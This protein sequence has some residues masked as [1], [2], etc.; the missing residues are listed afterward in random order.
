MGCEVMYVDECVVCV[1]SV[2]GGLLYSNTLSA[3]VCP[4]P[5]PVKFVISPVL[6][7]AIAC[8]RQYFSNII[9]SLGISEIAANLFACFIILSVFLGGFG[10]GVWMCRVC[11]SIV[12]I[13]QK[14]QD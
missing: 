11:V 1:M 5:F 4:I 8:L 13:S 6:F 2:V 10:C 7:T 3:G 14:A 9:C 12:Y